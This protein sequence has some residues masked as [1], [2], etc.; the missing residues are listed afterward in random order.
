M[1]NQFTKDLNKFKED[2]VL[3]LHDTI[4]AKYTA[5]VGLFGSEDIP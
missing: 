2:M 3:T 1:G 5:N 4:D